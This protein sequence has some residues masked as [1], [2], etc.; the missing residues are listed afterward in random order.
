MPFELDHTIRILARTPDVLRVL[1]DG[2]SEGWWH[3]TEG[4]DTWSPF[5]VVGHLIHG[6]ETNWIPRAQII[7]E[8]GESRQFEPFDRFAQFAD[9]EDKS[10][11]QLLDE[12]A[13]R[14]ARSVETLRAWK[15]S[16]ADL[17]RRGRHPE[18]GSVTLRELLATWVVHD[19]GHLG[20]ITRVMAKRYGG[21]VGPWKAYLRVLGD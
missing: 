2:L 21:A 18:F 13:Q 3:H 14:R 20:Q 8:R 9:S 6:E 15:L 12:F 4:P 11:R 1:L 16:D 5:D 10:P 17:D 7:L 19:F